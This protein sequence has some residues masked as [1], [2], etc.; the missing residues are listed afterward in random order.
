MGAL[1]VQ[2]GPNTGSKV[3]GF[4]IFWAYPCSVAIAFSMIASNVAGFTKKSV[5]TSMATLGY[6]AGN[7]VG[8]FLFFPREKPKYQ[9]RVE[10]RRS[11]NAAPELT[12]VC[13]QSGFTG[14]ATCFGIAI[15]LMLSLIVVIRY[16]NSRRDKV[17]GAVDQSTLN[18]AEEEVSTSDQT[19]GE[20]KVFRYMM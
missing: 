8:P 11:P 13:P 17:F 18:A 19:D 3:F 5:A 6:C 14:T 2:F 10:C 1:L 7:I 9:V 15:F 16:E 20:N 4:M 12:C